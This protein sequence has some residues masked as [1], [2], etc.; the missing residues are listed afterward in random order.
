VHGDSPFRASIERSA[1][2]VC[3]AVEEVGRG[4]PQG[5]TAAHDALDG[6]GIAIVEALSRRWGCDEV[7]GGKEFWAELASEPTAPR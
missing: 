5:R 4:L 3:I 1:D 7:D 2:A 6:R